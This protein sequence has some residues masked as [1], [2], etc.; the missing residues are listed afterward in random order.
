MKRIAITAG[1]ILTSLG[2]LE[3]TWDGLLRGQCGLVAEDFSSV[4]TKYPLGLI[5]GLAGVGGSWQRL[6]SVVDRLLEDIPPLHE[7]TRL[8]CATTK[9]AVDELIISASDVEGQPYQLADYIKKELGL[10]TDATTVSGACAS[11]SLAIVQAAMQLAAGECEYALVV[12]VDLVAQFILAGFD[13]LKALSLAAAKPFDRNRDGLSLGDGGGWILL[14]TEDHFVESS[15]T[16]LAWFEG[17]GISCDATHITAPC[18]YASGLKSALKQVLPY[19]GSRPGGINAHGTGTVYNDAMELLAFRDTYAEQVPV[20]SVKGALGHSLAAA[21][22]IE[23][24]LSVESLHS[25]FLPPT[26]GCLEPEDGVNISGSKTLPLLNSSI[27]CCN[28][29]F[30]GI[31]CVLYLTR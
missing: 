11:G 8:F 24:M 10:S 14:S 9:A 29:G 23:T 21:G 2:D 12:G 25:A 28:S 5:Q 4:A 1:N 16:P 17:W 26:V 19:S 6:K 15:A 13:S 27:I 30:G 31:N 3:A 7:N 20:C 22:V 18:R